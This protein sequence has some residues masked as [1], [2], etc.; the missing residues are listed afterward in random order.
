MAKDFFIIS[1][2]TGKKKKMSFFSPAEALAHPE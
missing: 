2:A 1:I